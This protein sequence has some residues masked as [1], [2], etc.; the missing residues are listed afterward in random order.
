MMTFSEKIPH[1]LDAAM[2]RAAQ[3]RA[4]RVA[5]MYLQ[6]PLGRFELD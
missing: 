2:I 4:S 6:W 3:A 1:H 5:F